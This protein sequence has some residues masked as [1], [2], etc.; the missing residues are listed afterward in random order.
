MN[1]AEL[2]AMGREKA[3]SAAPPAPQ[4]GMGAASGSDDCG[5]TA[6]PSSD[7]FFSTGARSEWLLWSQVTAMRLVLSILKT[8]SS[9]L[10]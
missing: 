8:A 5:E 1:T 3:G 2:F 4:H 9:M 7:N 6:F 10:L